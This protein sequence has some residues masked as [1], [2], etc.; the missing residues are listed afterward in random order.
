MDQEQILEKITTMVDEERR[1]RA[2]AQA[3]EVDRAEEN[4]RLRA[5]EVQLDQCW[6]LLRQRRA[7]QEF[8]QDPEEVHARP[9]S[10]VEGYLA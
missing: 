9:A 2:S 5:L 3:G 10:Q 7:K 8:G 6:D 4:Q 1:L